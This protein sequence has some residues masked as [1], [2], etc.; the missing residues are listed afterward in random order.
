MQWVDFSCQMRYPS[1]TFQYITW[2]SGSQV[3]WTLNSAGMAADSKVEISA[4][5][6]S[7]EPMVRGVFSSLARLAHYL[8]M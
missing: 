4:R 5:P 1:D 3:S 2:Y 6:I 8:V 7:Q